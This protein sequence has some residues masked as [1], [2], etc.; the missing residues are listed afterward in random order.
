VPELQ[1]KQWVQCAAHLYAKHR[2]LE[3]VQVPA[4]RAAAALRV[5]V[6]VLVPPQR[7][8]LALGLRQDLAQA[9][10]EVF[11][12]QELVAELLVKAL[13]FYQPV[14]RLRSC[15]AQQL[16]VCH[17]ATLVASLWLQMTFY[18][19]ETKHRHAK[20]PAVWLGLHRKAK[21]EACWFSVLR[22]CGAQPRLGPECRH[23]CLHGWHIQHLL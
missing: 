23:V 17:L 20:G 13:L 6:R 4:G 3:Q 16:D 1:L 15:P 10:H 7:T 19:V 14:Q 18:A 11:Q 12:G 5:V 2:V 21:T 22:A 8:E 9:E